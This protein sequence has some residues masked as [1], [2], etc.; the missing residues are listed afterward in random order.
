MNRSPQVNVYIHSVEKIK[1]KTNANLA[2]EV[3]PYV[4]GFIA[5]VKNCFPIQSQTL[6]PL[7][8]LINVPQKWGNFDSWFYEVTIKPMIS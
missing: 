8:V 3:H 6:T 1:F 2:L 4:R 7:R 5:D